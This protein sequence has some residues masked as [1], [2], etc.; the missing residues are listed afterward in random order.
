MEGHDE[1]PA[2]LL[3]GKTDISHDADNAP[4]RHQHAEAFPPN[5]VQFI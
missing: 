1:M 2:I 4:T 3:A 5:F